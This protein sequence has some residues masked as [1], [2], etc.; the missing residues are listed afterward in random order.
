MSDS[1]LQLLVMFIC[2]AAETGFI[3][4]FHNTF[5][6]V[7]RRHSIIKK[8]LSIWTVSFL[9]FLLISFV[10]VPTGLRYVFVFAAYLWYSLF[11]RGNWYQKILST[12][13]G[14]FL[15]MFL[16]TGLLWI[17][18]LV[19][20]N[21]LQDVFA[22]QILAIVNEAVLLIVGLFLATLGRLHR[23]RQRITSLQWVLTLFYPF[24]ALT[25]LLSLWQFSL[26]NRAST[27]LLLDAFLLLAALSVH[28]LLVQALSKQN[29]VVE[30]EHLLQQQLQIE[31]EK[32][33]ALTQAYTAQRKLTHEFRHHLDALSGL[34][35]QGEIEMAKAY[36]RDLAPQT[37][38]GS[39]VV[40]TKNPLL[41]AILSQKYACAA[42]QGN[43]L[44][45]QLQ[46]LQNPKISTPDL[47]VIVSNLLDNALEAVQKVPEG[48][49]EFKIQ[50]T[51]DEFLISVRNQVKENITI[52]NNE[53]PRT[54]KISGFNGMGL[55]NT[56]AVL[57]KYNADHIIT[58]RDGWFQFTALAETSIS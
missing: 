19:S 37:I 39:Y 45:F 41:D 27:V 40:N 7:D 32:A 53:P 22:S 51:E 18:S 34:L 49:I 26:R 44:Y 25:V 35:S 3:L 5:L 55:P 15:F 8:Y 6:G 17:E 36:I 57:E 52:V 20:S 23:K 47:V 30:Q 21:E 38:E 24:V 50:Q 29:L 56:I 9:L 33:E 2:N 16:G 13:V 28:F 46:D 1:T 31:N 14:F 4:L 54:T 42:K 43:K 10:A 58:C 12:F 11:Y 48:I